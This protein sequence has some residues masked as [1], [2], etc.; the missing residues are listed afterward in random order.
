MKMN[1]ERITI[2]LLLA[3][4][5]FCGWALYNTVTVSREMSTLTDEAISMTDMGRADPDSFDALG[6]KLGEISRAS[7]LS[8][9]IH[10][11]TSWSG[12]RRQCG[13]SARFTRAKSPASC[14][15]LSTRHAQPLT[16]SKK[17]NFPQ[18]PIFCESPTGKKSPDAFNSIYEYHKSGEKYLLINQHEKQVL[19]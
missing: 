15:S 13:S 4:L 3:L 10:G 19:F 5:A 12:C 16:T 2:V 8:P 6:Q 17:P 11:T 14:I 18:L 1:R 7:R 9:P